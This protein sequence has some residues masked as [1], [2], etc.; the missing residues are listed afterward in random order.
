MYKHAMGL[1]LRTPSG[2]HSTTITSVVVY[3]QKGDT[4]S[5]GRGKNKLHVE[6]QRFIVFKVEQEDKMIECELSIEE[7]WTDYDHRDNLGCP[8]DHT[9]RLAH[10]RFYWTD[11]HRNSNISYENSLLIKA[12]CTATKEVAMDIFQFLFHKLILNPEINDYMDNLEHKPGFIETWIPEY[13]KFRIRNVIQE[14]EYK[15]KQVH[16][17]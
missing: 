6:S 4:Y 16:E 7:R 8:R 1:H 13:F 15:V 14:R 11:M 12:F 2:P 9:V 5:S 17:A 3:A 10:K